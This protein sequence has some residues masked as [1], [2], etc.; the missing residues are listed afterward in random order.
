[1]DDW[2]DIFHIALDI[3][4]SIVV[5]TSLMFVLNLGHDVS[6]KMDANRAENED[7]NNY[8]VA[9]MY[10][11]S[12]CYAQDI[13]SLIL[14]YQGNPKVL[15]TAQSGNVMEWSTKVFYTQL[16]SK[17]IGYVLNQSSTYK[18]TLKYDANESLEAYQFKEE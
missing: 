10:E 9:R 18:C 17:D 3:L 14:E 6:G 15:V 4:V 1:M 2:K 7:I 11:D 13:V 8:R 12:D 5:I 16:T